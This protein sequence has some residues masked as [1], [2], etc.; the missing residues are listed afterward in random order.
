[1]YSV[2]ACSNNT[3]NCSLWW[4]IFNQPMFKP[5]A[6]CLIFCFW[7]WNYQRSILCMAHCVARVPNQQFVMFVHLLNSLF[8]HL[9][10][11]LFDALLDTWKTEPYSFLCRNSHFLRSDSKRLDLR[12]FTA[13]CSLLFTFPA[14]FSQRIRFLLR[15]KHDRPVVAAKRLQCCMHSSGVLTSS[16]QSTSNIAN[17][18]GMPR[19]HGTNFR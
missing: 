12:L 19:R 3:P 6:G 4:R 2:T 15:F 14:C 11:S 17:G 16:L 7:S 13:L 10:N 9:L 5:K 18:H 1:M 8:V